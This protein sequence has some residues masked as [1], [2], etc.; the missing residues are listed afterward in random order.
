MVAGDYQP[1]L[2]SIVTVL[3]TTLFLFLLFTAAALADLASVD[4]MKRQ[5]DALVLTMGV[6]S[7]AQF[8]YLNNRYALHQRNWSFQTRLEVSTLAAYTVVVVIRFNK[9]T[10]Y[11]GLTGRGGGYVAL[12]FALPHPLKLSLLATAIIAQ[13]SANAGDCNFFK[14]AS[15]LGLKSADTQQTLPD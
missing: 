14:T 11:L 1:R 7:Q 10:G 4:N 15:I 5:Q 12:K 13:S 8:F 2:D 9:K 6:R 3:I